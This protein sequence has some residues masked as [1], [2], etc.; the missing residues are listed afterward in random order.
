[1][2][3]QLWTRRERR[4]SKSTRKRGHTAEVN[5]VLQN[6]QQQFQGARQSPAATSISNSH[7][8]PEDFS[9]H[10]HIFDPVAVESD[11]AAFPSIEGYFQGSFMPGVADFG[12]P[13]DGALGA[14]GMLSGGFQDWDLGQA[15][16]DIAG[17]L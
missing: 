13:F 17:G 3:K 6:Q 9:L 10:Q 5:N 2:L 4:H 16:L 7:S 12:S 8:T 14:Q 15:G 11:L 1:M